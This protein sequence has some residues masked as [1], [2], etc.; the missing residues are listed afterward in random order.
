VRRHRRRDLAR[1]SRYVGNETPASGNVRDPLPAVGR[2]P[3]DSRIAVPQGDCRADS[4]RG[5]DDDDCG[6]QFKAIAK[7]A[8]PDTD[9]LAM[10]FGTFNMIAGVMSLCCSCS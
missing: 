7:Q 8:V 4:D 5:V 1:S 3:A 2:L 6:W 9:E 10:F